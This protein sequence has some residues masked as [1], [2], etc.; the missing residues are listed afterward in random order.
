MKFKPGKLPHSK[1][2]SS[3]GQRKTFSMFGRSGKTEDGLMHKCRLCSIPRKV[4]EIDMR[5]MIGG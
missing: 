1:R 2:C 3:C 5:G 4:E